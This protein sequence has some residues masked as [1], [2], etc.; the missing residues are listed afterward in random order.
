MAR[1]NFSA[2]CEIF[3]HITLCCWSS[4]EVSWQDMDTVNTVNTDFV[5]RLHGINLT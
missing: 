5:H 4:L 1:N 3:F 2:N